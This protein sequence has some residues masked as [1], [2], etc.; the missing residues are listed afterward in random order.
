MRS[1][2]SRVGI[3]GRTYIRSAADT[4]NVVRI[5]NK[6]TLT[7]LDK[8]GTRYRPPRPRHVERRSKKFTIPG[9]ARGQDPLKFFDTLGDQLRLFPPPAADRPLL[10]ALA[11]VGIGPGL[12][13]S[14]EPRRGGAIR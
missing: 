11:A 6:Y 3:I 8:W 2:Y 13:P 7:P 12:H 5:Q 4:P 1:P 9:T 14:A 10:R